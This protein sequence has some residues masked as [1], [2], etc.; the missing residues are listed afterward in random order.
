MLVMG[1]GFYS[2]PGNAIP[3]AIYRGEGVTPSPQ[4]SPVG[5]SRRRALPGLF[6]QA[7]LR[8]E[9]ERP[10]SLRGGTLLPRAA[11]ANRRAISRHR[12]RG[13][14]R[15]L[16]APFPVRRFAP[17]SVARDL[18]HGLSFAADSYNR[19]V[20]RGVPVGG[21]RSARRA[22]PLARGRFG[23]NAGF[24]AV[25]ALAGAGCTGGA[26]RGVA[27]PG[28]VEVVELDIAGI[29]DGLRSGR[30]TCE[31][32]V[33][34][35]LARIEAYDR[36][37]PALHAIVT[38]NPEAVTEA[39]ALDRRIAEN[40]AFRPLECVPM[41]VK[42]NYD[43]ADLPTS[44]GSASLRDSRPP[45]DAFQ[46]ARVLEAG[47]VVLA[48][49]NMAEFAFSPFESLGS[50]VPGHTRNPYDPY[51]VPAGSSGGTAA[52]VAASFGAVGL[53]TDTGNS[54]RGPSS[55]TALAGIRSTMGLT[56]R[57]G[58]V[59]LNLYRDIGGPMART[60]EDAVRV[61]EVLAGP[62]PAD[63]ATAGVEREADYRAAL[64]ASSLA[65]FRVGVVRQLSDTETADPE[66]A[67]LFEQAL[68]DL[69]RLG[70]EVADPVEIGGLDEDL[71]LW[72]NPFR[73]HLEAY[74]ES[75]G[76]G[77]PA[78]TLA[79]ILDGGDF[80]PSIESRLERAQAV[81]EPPEVECAEA[82]AGAAALR[83][84]VEALFRAESLDAL[85]YPSWSNPPR[86]LG[87]LTT[88]DGNNSYQL[89]PPT[90]FP[91]V[92]VP[93]GFTPAGLPAGLQLLGATLGESTLFRIAY[94]YE[95]ATER[96]RPPEATPPLRH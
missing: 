58:I 79:E 16:P 91:A 44:A 43:T 85:A 4:P 47:A 92:T 51:R 7:V 48:K 39:R 14:G 25:A 12:R 19:F 54:I 31:A 49:S 81:E 67:A 83:S 52:A 6:P 28:T 70:A 10:R 50:V 33:E 76:P 36:R 74:L 30:F 32:L 18:L 56:S 96:R 24:A 65:G 93:M 55:H 29:H 61:F 27:G 80:H 34:A 1:R 90:G 5:A 41:I 45:D 8:P 84:E 23:A 75:L 62:D 82:L 78:R 77:A 71:T 35:Y 20:A 9:A 26:D 63:A 13:A 11:G 57:D 22:A 17:T 46:V 64:D 38:V 3:S 73:A 89:S 60:V 86:L 42:D 88:P 40:G 59:P 53:G 66:I 37:G 21:S 2:A 69:E 87:D 94:A 72:C 95:Q 15:L 68:A